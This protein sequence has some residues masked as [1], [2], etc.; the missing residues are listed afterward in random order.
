M[1]QRGRARIGQEVGGLA[2][3]AS[4]G[5]RI[6]F[7]IFF[8]VIGVMA[9]FGV[10]AFIWY[11]VGSGAYVKTITGVPS[12]GGEITQVGGT[13]ITIDPDIPA[14]LLTI[15]ND[16]VVTISGVSSDSA[17]AL[18]LASTQG[19][20]V[21]P[22]AGSNT[23]NLK[24]DG[25]ITV[26]GASPTSG[27]ELTLVGG[28]GTT[29]V[30]GVNQVT[31]NNDG[32][33]T[34]SGVSP[35]A[36]GEVSLA[37]GAGITISPSP[38]T[39]MVGINNIGVLT[40]SGVGP[41]GSG[42]VSVNSGTG[43][44]VTPDALNNL[45]TVNNDGVLSLTP[46][47]GMATSGT[48]GHISIERGIDSI[49]LSLPNTDPSGGDISYFHQFG[50][51][52]PI[53]ENTWRMGVNTGFYP[54]LLPGPVA[55]DGGQGNTG[56]QWI[57]PADGRYS[58]SIHCLFGINTITVNDYHAIHAALNLG[59]TTVDPEASGWIPPGGF[60]MVHL[61]TGTLSGGSAIPKIVLGSTFQA[62]PTCIVNTGDV[63][64]VH[65]MHEHYG[66]G[67]AAVAIADCR[68]H[69]SRLI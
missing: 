31:I 33:L 53:A 41:S 8:G 26:S 47:Y 45:M 9:V 40:I 42:E 36:G 69:V 18:T 54:F 63:L 3:T 13:G 22:D 15:K 49:T 12:K 56:T 60:G 21:T 44:T 59:A 24:N 16:G 27:G 30:P 46:S 61:S 32:I 7:W 50:S 62:C 28:Q 65:M 14:G 1:S 64:T 48:T 37:G 19:I 20:T 67:P 68:I 51:L 25:V 43:I 17:G 29:V 58:V 23:V 66:V 11:A 2:P 5:G 10:S 55:G 39:N 35:T 4:P 52:T 38:G 6:A 34:L 57:V